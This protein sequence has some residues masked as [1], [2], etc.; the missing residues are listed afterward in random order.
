MQGN[1]GKYAWE[2]SQVDLTEKI[3]SAVILGTRKQK[4]LILIPS[5]RDSSKW[6]L[7]FPDVS[8]S[9][10]QN[11]IVYP[12]ERGPFMERGC[13]GSEIKWSGDSVAAWL[14]RQWACMGHWTCLSFTFL[15][16]EVR[17]P[18]VS[19]GLFEAAWQVHRMPGTVRGTLWRE[20]DLLPSFAF[21]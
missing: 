21:E 1:N 14:F 12:P 11:E 9:L 6:V 2:E 13:T 15:S 5:K 20:L 17:I 7:F 19:Q 4:L 8:G 18:K 16:W 3:F 10:L